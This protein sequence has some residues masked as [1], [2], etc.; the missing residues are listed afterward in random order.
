MS[1]RLARAIADEIAA[2]GPITFARFMERALYDPLDGDYV[3]PPI[4][5]DRDYVTS[6][7]VSRAFAELLARELR[8]MR[9]EIGGAF[10]VVEV[11]A[12]DG[13]LAEQIVGSGVVARSAWVAVERSAGAQAALRARGFDVRASAHDVE[14]FEGVLLAHEVLDNVPF[15]RIRRRGDDLV[16]VFVDVR[17]GVFVEAE[18]AV[19]E[20]ARSAL[21]DRPSGAEFPVSPGWLSFIRDATSVVARGWVIVIDLGFARGEPAQSVR[22]YAG[23]RTTSDVLTD[24]GSRD[25]TTGVD[26]AALAAAAGDMQVWGPVT[27]REMLLALGLREWLGSLRDRQ[28]QATEAGLSREAVSLFAERSRAPLLADPEHLGALK[29]LVLGRGV[30][31]PSFAEGAKRPR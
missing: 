26:F 4:G 24:P 20:D 15:H 14:P 12:G 11:G 10:R 13:T 17:D 21:V 8:R 27:Q 30:G 29:V 1:E 16:E 2:H 3:R 5:A 6:P 23:Q 18:R 19:S 31:A 9:D 22:A 7:H 28:V 25:I